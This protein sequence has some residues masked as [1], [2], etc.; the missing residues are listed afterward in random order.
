M[1]FYDCSYFRGTMLQADFSSCP[2]MVTGTVQAGCL[3][4]IV[5]QGT[6][7]TQLSILKRLPVYVV[8]QTGYQQVGYAG[9]DQ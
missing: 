5:Q 7:D 4:Y 6:T 2:G 3:G 8:L 1:L 9:D